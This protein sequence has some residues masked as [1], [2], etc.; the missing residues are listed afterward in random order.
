MKSKYILMMLLV[1]IIC[2]TNT[3]EAQQ[4]NRIFEQIGGGS[5]QPANVKESNDNTVFYIAGAAIVAGIV[6]YAILSDKKSG[7]AKEDTTA[8]LN[9]EELINKHLSFNKMI[10]NYQTAIPISISAGIQNDIVRI[11]EKRYFLGLSYNF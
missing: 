3:S 4:V 7:K 9:D 1:V 6:I 10:Q 5:G 8:V 11:E 2:L